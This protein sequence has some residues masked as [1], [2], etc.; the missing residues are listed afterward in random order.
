MI[1][2]DRYWGVFSPEQEEI[3]LD[4]GMHFLRQERIFTW[5]FNA[6]GLR[7]EKTTL[8]V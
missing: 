5:Y 6:A 7:E 2:V 4:S 8:S 1:K 3:L